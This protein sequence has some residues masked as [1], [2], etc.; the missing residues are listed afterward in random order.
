MRRQGGK[1]SNSILYQKFQPCA[2]LSR[3]AP[4]LSIIPTWKKSGILTEISRVFV[5]L[6][7]VER[8]NIYHA[9]N[10][11][12]LVSET[13]SGVLTPTTSLLRWLS[14]GVN[15]YRGAGNQVKTILVVNWLYQCDACAL[16]FVRPLAIRHALLR[17]E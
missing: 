1:S 14:N 4:A 11:H 15:V 3:Y 10:L 13:S 16:S 17:F 9:R 12:I 6:P 7:L 8:D 5:P 2:F